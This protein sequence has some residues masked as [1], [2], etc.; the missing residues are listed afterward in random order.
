MSARTNLML[1]VKHFRFQL[2][3]ICVFLGVANVS[4]RAAE[5]SESRNSA[6]GFF[7]GV[8]SKI[9][10]LGTRV[11]DCLASRCA[12]DS[13]VIWILSRSV[14]Q[15]RIVRGLSAIPRWLPETEYR[16]LLASIGSLPA[17]NPRLESDPPLS[18]VLSER[19]EWKTSLLVLE[20]ATGFPTERL[21]AVF[22]PK[23]YFAELLSPSSESRR[24]LLYSTGEVLAQSD[25]HFS[26]ALL[27][28]REYFRKLSTEAVSQ[29]RSFD[30]LDVTSY[31]RGISEIGLIMLFESPI[32]GGV[33]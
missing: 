10:L 17:P 16:R 33:S 27:G 5:I 22:D 7:L 26:G 20:Y 15:S 32:L 11:K 1:P 3:V 13:E 28:D 29:E 25:S 24:W 18:M 8:E 14:G 21:I 19:D 6:Q 30:Q 23:R 4:L 31:R 9:H 2:A 12:E